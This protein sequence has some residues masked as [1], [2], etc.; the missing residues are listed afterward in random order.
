[1]LSACFVVNLPAAAFVDHLQ[2]VHTGAC[3]RAES[4]A[5]YF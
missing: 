2:F 1:M 5:D 3:I 4:A